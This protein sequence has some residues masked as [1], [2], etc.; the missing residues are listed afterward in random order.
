VEDRVV[1]W[2]ALVV[3]EPLIDPQLS[4]V[5]FAY[6]SGLWVRDALRQLAARP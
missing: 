6:R 3:L 4:P 2:A 5:S 1:E